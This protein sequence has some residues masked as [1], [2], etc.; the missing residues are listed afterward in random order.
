MMYVVGELGE[1]DGDL[2]KNFV[3]EVLAKKFSLPIE[4][5]EPTGEWLLDPVQ[6]MKSN[7]EWAGI[8]LSLNMSKLLLSQWPQLPTEVGETG[9]TDILLRQ[10]GAWWF[11]CFLREALREAVI[12]RA[13]KLDTHSLAYIIGSGELAGLGASVAIQLGFRRLIM[14]C[15]DGEEARQLAL[16]IQKKF[17]GL[18]LVLI[19]ESQL[20]LQPSNGSL[21]INTLGASSGA[22]VLND[23]P[24]LNFLK[25]DGLVVDLPYPDS[26]DQLVDEAKHVGISYIRGGEVLGLRDFL[27]LKSMMKS[28]FSVSRDVYFSEWKSRL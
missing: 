12:R 27:F 4:W 13:P 14:V 6:A 2:R 22:A 24:Y 5:R 17:F 21:L 7:Q 16:R 10:D 26:L 19:L 9:V 25:K 1:S 23:L 3:T 15:S 28:E 20:T 8:W 11:R 18:E